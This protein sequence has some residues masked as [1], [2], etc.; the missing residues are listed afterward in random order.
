VD[1]PPA[2][3]RSAA[4]LGRVSIDDPGPWV[5]RLSTAALRRPDGGRQVGVGPGSVVLHAGA[6]D[7]GLETAAVLGPALAGVPSGPDGSQSAE[8]AGSGSCS[9]LGAGPLASRLRHALG[10]RCSASP[11]AVQVQVLVH[12]SVVPPDVGVAVARSGRPALPVVAQPQRVL[13]GPVVGVSAGPCLHCLDLHRRDRD[14]GWPALATALGHP[15]EQAVPL[16][17]PEPLARASEGLVLLLV[18][19]LLAGRPVSSGVVHELGPCAPHVVTR[20]WA[21]HPACPWHP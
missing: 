15:A 5:R 2:E 12:Q 10:D 11:E 20:R 6:D 9:V 13:V 1:N 4:S 14:A 21:A 19:S 16:D 18:S 7:Q 8:A 3:G 17:L